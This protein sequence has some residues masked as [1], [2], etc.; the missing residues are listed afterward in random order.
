MQESDEQY[1]KKINSILKEYLNVFNKIK[2]EAANIFSLE[3][4]L[5]SKNPEGLFFLT[6]NEEQKREIKEEMI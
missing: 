4:G 2:S 5:S 6:F 1:K 3:Y